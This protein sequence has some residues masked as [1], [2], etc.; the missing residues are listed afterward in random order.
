MNSIKASMLTVDML[1]KDQSGCPFIICSNSN[2][3]QRILSEAGYKEQGINLA[4][5]EM[6]M[7]YES[8]SRPQHVEAALKIITNHQTPIIFTNFEML[9][10]PR[11]EI[12]ILKFFCEKARLVNVAVKWPGSFVD[13]K[14]IYATTED[15]DYH[16]F[17]CNAYQIRIIQ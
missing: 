15:P 3:V 11:Y 6:L 9:F 14:L 4:L 13:D 7:R 5:S 2:R 10:D 1:K 8:D 17:N 16:E 12:D